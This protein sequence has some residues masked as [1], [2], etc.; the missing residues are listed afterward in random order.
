LSVT[1][2]RAD[3]FTFIVRLS[4]PPPPPPPPR[5]DVRWA[6]PTPQHVWIPGHWSIDDDHNGW[7][8]HPGYWEFP[9]V[10]WA[11]WEPAHHRDYLGAYYWVKGHWVY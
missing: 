2:A 4:A 1:P 8:W 11:R 6:P 7:I 9:P 3:S 5:V 10:P